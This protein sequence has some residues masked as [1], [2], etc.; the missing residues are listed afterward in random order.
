M[1]KGAVGSRANCVPHNTTLW[2][3]AASRSIAALRSPEVISSFS[4]GSA[5][6]N[7]RG[8][9]VRSRIAQ[10]ISKSFSA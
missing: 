8:N 6:N 2:S 3:R 4:V 5:A 10:M 9:G 7:V 1:V